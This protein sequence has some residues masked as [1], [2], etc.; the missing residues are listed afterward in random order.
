MAYKIVFFDVDGTLIN[1]EKEIPESTIEAV[2]ELQ[3]K[4]I[5]TV[6]ATGRAPY[7][8]QEIA[9]KLAI[10]S[11]ICLNGAIT[12]YK[13]EP[14]SDYP[15]SRADLE[16]LAKR[17]AEHGHPV[18]YMGKEA[19]YADTLND[20]FVEESIRYLKV[21]MPGYDPDYWKKANVYQA[22]LYC[23]ADEQHHYE[24]MSPNLRLIRWHPRALDVV[25]AKGSKARGMLDLLQK[26]NIR[27][28]EAV[29]FG[30]AMNDREML[31]QAGLGIAMGNCEDGV[32]PY[33]D[34]VTTHVDQDGIRNG[35]IYAGLL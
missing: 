1:E 14:I 22:L 32:R 35:L 18:V 7:F 29:A 4:G 21:I 5:Q 8:I 2:A 9:Q 30:D 24:H 10:D 31:R 17:A 33:A 3:R 27:P 20:P 19:Y 26:L 23:G 34:Y 25:L 16:L 13:G 15:I 12:Q 28:E 11:W 6:I